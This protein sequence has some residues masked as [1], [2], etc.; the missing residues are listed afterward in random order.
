MTDFFLEYKEYITPIL[1][2]FLGIAI[3]IAS[4]PQQMKIDF[5]DWLD[6]GNEL[7]IASILCL[8]TQPHENIGYFLLFC[9]FIL[10]LL[11]VGLVNRIGWDIIKRKRNIWGVIIPDIAGLFFFVIVILIERGIIK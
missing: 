6:F 11:V 9:A 10:L 4:K 5:F 1:T 7:S 3:K 2:I 8:T